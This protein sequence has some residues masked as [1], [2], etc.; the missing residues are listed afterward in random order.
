LRGSAA[1]LIL[2]PSTRTRCSFEIAEA[3]LGMERVTLT[4]AEGLSLVKGE[5]LEDTARTLAAMGVGTFVVRHPVVGAPHRVAEALPGVHVV[6]AG[7]GTGEHPTQALLDLLVLWRRWGELAGR[8]VLIVGDVVHSRVAR[9]NVHGLGAL[10]AEVVLCGPRHLLPPA[11]GAPG[12]SRTEDLDGALER[13]DAVMTLR[14]QRERLADGERA[15]DPAAY[16]EAYGLTEERVARL[17]PD[18]P[19]L[20]PGPFNREV[21]IDSGVADGPR[22]LIWSQVRAGVAVRMAVL[23]ALAGS[24]TGPPDTPAGE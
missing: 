5:T 13:C 15:L 9:S 12:V 14:I 23:E 16:R 10:G 1:N 21:E 4:V 18:V 24:A 19:V 6:N 17:H 22:S 3:R 11:D 8:A 2:E 20:H 7:D